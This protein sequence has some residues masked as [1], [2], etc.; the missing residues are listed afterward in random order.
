MPLFDEH[1]T[2]L[3]ISVE[4]AFRDVKVSGFGQ[5]SRAAL[6]RNRSAGEQTFLPDYVSRDAHGPDLVRHL[7]ALTIYQI[8]GTEFETQ[9]QD[10]DRELLAAIDRSLGTACV[11]VASF[12]RGPLAPIAGTFVDVDDL[13]PPFC[14]SYHQARDLVEQSTKPL[15]R[16]LERVLCRI[17]E[18]I[19][20]TKVWELAVKEVSGLDESRLAELAE[21]RRKFMRF[22]MNETGETLEQLGE[23][24]S[25]EFI[26]AR[27]ITPP[28]LL[29][30][31]Q[32]I[33]E[34]VSA[35]ISLA[36]WSH[37]VSEEE[38][39]NCVPLEFDDGDPNG[40]DIE[41]P[42]RFQ[43]GFVARN[44]SFLARSRGSFIGIVTAKASQAYWHREKGNKAVLSV[45]KL[46]DY[47]VPR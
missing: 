4:Q 17:R 27:S 1:P 34:T 40:Y 39:T 38:C 37:E 33:F 18:Q 15:P 14:R 46:S 20:Q 12:W 28:A 11:I 23:R 13:P 47:E 9:P 30:F 36:V 43:L 3:E 24:L 35:L 32:L 6:R 44:S 2:E 42:D 25:R 26:A 29:Q 22:N 19:E 8:T 41:I 21:A 10:V 31:N 5:L 7:N 16:Q 45:I